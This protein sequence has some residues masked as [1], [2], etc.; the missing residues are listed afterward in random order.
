[1]NHP[2]RFVFPGNTMP[3]SSAATALS[4]R[5]RITAIVFGVFAVLTKHY[6]LQKPVHV[7][8]FAGSLLQR[9]DWDH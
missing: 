5:W 2:Y 9:G 1:M 8:M 3:D 4:R 6:P 7:G